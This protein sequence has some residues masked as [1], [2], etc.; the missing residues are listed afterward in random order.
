MPGLPVLAGQLESSGKQSNH[1]VIVHQL[2]HDTTAENILVTYFP[3]HV[4]KVLDN[5]ERLGL[6]KYSEIF[7]DRA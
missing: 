4:I 5:A 3:W 6:K 1:V 7:R 2:S